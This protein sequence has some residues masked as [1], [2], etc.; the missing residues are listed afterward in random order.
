MI[1]PLRIAVALVGLLNVVLGLLF[2]IHPQWMAAQFYVSPIGSQGLATIRA[3]F[4]GF[5]LAAGVFALLGAR[6]LRAEPL[7]VPIFLFAVA[8]IGR[9]LSLLLDGVGPMAFPPMIAE[10]VMI[11]I[12]CFAGRAFDAARPGAGSGWPFLRKEGQA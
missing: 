8:F 3:D 12:L 6:S 10:A 11:A 1:Q 7:T 9:A 2:L 4:T 5:F